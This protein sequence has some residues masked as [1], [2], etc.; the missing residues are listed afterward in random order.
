MKRGGKGTSSALP[1]AV[2]L[3]IVW[4][5][6]ALAAS[7]PSEQELGEPQQPELSELPPPELF[8]AQW[9]DRQEFL[10]DLHPAVRDE[11]LALR[12]SPVY[13]LDWLLESPDSLAGQQETLVTNYSQDDWENVY[14]LLHPNLLGASFVLDSVRLNGEEVQY[15]LEQDGWLL[16]LDPSGGIKAGESAVV[17]LEYRLSIP[18]TAGR[19][20]GI[21]AFRDG[22]LSLAHGYA[23]LAVYGE[24]G[25]DLDVPPEHGDL[26]HARS[27]FFRVR[28]DAPARFDIVSSGQVRQ[29]SRDGDRR[30]LEFVAGPVR[31]F[32]LAGAEEMVTVER[33]VGETTVRGHAPAQLRAAMEDAVGQASRAVSF[34]GELYGTYAYLQLDLV[35]ISTE[36]LGVEFPGAIA[37]RR[38]ILSGSERRRLLESTVVHEVVHQWYYGMVGNDQV[39]EPW[40]DES[41]TQYLTLRY[42]QEFHGEDGYRAFRQDLFSR[43]EAIDR[44]RVPIGLPA[45]AYDQEEY[46]AIVYGLGPIVIEW[47]ADLLE[48]SDFDAFL[49][50]YTEEHLF[51]LARS[52]DF[53]ELAEEQCECSLAQFFGRWVTGAPV[54]E[55]VLFAPGPVKGFGFSE[56]LHAP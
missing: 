41:L 4:P 28:V 27:S 32:Y 37:L 53:R 56:R 18:T 30:M 8:D 55:Y 43:W 3:L 13:H 26:V 48:R 31:D 17:T 15:A 47:L 10:A 35:V 40:L 54:P 50:A 33:Q 2:L 49:D 20:Y 12:G 6:L 5:A 25:W 34:L 22:T 52:E 42:F 39:S 1:V 14:F 36:A 46:G 19:N 9:G 7:Q 51:G 21:L 11:A 45:D 16:R 23:L 38:Q 24:G 44:R 29:E